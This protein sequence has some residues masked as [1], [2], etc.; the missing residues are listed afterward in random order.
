MYGIHWNPQCQLSFSQHI[1]PNKM[2]PISFIFLLLYFSYIWFSFFFLFVIYFKEEKNDFVF[3][4]CFCCCLFSNN[5][6]FTI[7][8]QQF[9]LCSRKVK[10]LTDLFTH[11]QCWSGKKGNIFICVCL[12]VCVLFMLEYLCVL[13]MLE[14]LFVCIWTGRCFLKS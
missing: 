11:K 13:F 10:N 9:C 6:F 1:R 4:S 7:N 3:F 14:Y 5:F 8:R 12:C 2:N